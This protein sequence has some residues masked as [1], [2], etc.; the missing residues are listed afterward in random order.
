MLL[1]HDA[2]VIAEM[3]VRQTECPTSNSSEARLKISRGLGCHNYEWQVKAAEKNGNVEND[4][5]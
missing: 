3:Y 5:L 1:S 2:P 4:Q